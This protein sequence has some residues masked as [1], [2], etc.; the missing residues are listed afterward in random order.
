MQFRVLLTDEARSALDA[1]HGR[2]P[3]GADAAPTRSVD[4][5]S[6]DPAAAKQVDKALRW[7]AA[8]PRH[9][10]LRT[11]LY[12]SLKS[13]F[14]RDGQ[15]FESYAQNRTSGAMRLFWCYGQASGDITVLA[16]VR[17]PD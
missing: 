4:R 15:V 17:H 2:R 3:G 5:R 12:H 13:P 9:P 10:G 7:L 1:L 14:D 8:N 11:H 16:I 6:A